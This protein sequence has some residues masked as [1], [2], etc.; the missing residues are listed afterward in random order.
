MPQARASLRLLWQAHNKSRSSTLDSSPQSIGLRGRFFRGGEL[1]PRHRT[2]CFIPVYQNTLPGTGPVSL[3][4]VSVLLFSFNKALRKI[5]E[6]GAGFIRCCEVGAHW[7]FGCSFF[8]RLRT[9]RAL[10]E[11][12]PLK[13]LTLTGSSH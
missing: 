4:L 12:I 9:L 6:C 10:A 5:S 2:Q 3:Y 13:I 1:D 7:G 8:T 11:K